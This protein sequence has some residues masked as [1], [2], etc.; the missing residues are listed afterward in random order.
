MANLYQRH[1]LLDIDLVEEMAANRLRTTHVTIDT[2]RGFFK[3]Y[4]LILASNKEECVRMSHCNDRVVAYFSH[5]QNQGLSKEDLKIVK[6]GLSCV[7]SMTKAGITLMTEEICPILI[8]MNQLLPEGFRELVS[9][10]CEAFCCR[11]EDTQVQAQ[12]L[13]LSQ[14]FS[15]H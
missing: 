4:E 13:K 11:V 15:S 10:L 1:H 9:Q 8:V 7:L 12:I 6:M 5:L 3:L 14:R 2:Y